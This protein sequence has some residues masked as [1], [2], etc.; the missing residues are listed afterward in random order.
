MVDVYIWNIFLGRRNK[1]L[2]LNFISPI[3]C[4]LQKWAHKPFSSSEIREN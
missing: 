2:S 3:L 4:Y 1:M